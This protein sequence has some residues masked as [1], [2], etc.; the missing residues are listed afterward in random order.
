MEEK[1]SLNK[2]PET[3][4]MGQVN[5]LTYMENTETIRQKE[6]RTSDYL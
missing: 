3:C 2:I 4:H 6:Y 5:K 1:D